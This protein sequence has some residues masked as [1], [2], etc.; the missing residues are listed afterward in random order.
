MLQH[1]QVCIDVYILAMAPSGV[2]SFIAHIKHYGYYMFMVINAAAWFFIPDW[3]QV[4]KAT[5]IFGISLPNMQNLL[6]V[7]FHHQNMYYVR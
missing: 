3:T 5:N 2:H 4:L 1:W 6:V 7:N